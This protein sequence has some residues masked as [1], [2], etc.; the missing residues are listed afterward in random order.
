MREIKFRAYI[1]KQNKMVEITEMSFRKGW[2]EYYN[3][4]KEQYEDYYCT[5]TDEILNSQEII[6][7][8]YAGI[9]DKNGKEIYEGDI[10][11]LYFGC[12]QMDQRETTANA[13][14]VYCW[15]GYGSEIGFTGLYYGGMRVALPCRDSI[16]VIGNIYENHE[17]LEVEDK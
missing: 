15:N 3:Y 10:V 6:I 12:R 8:Q 7:M 4:E 13:E 2:F 1:K 14:I 5:D 16:E 11:K 17:L 9:K